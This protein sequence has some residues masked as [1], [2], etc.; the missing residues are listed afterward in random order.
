MTIQEVINSGCAIKVETKEQF[1]KAGVYLRSPYKEGDYIP[2]LPV[3]F[4]S[5]KSANR[6]NIGLG[7]QKEDKNIWN[8]RQLT[9]I[10]FDKIIFKD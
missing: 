10:P 1:K 8:R 6:G 7:Y 2:N 3:Y 9:V 4:V 5:P